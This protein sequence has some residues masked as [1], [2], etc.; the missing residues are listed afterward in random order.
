MPTSKA[1]ALRLWY[2]RK[3]WE[4]KFNAA[5]GR[6]EVWKGGKI[7]HA[8]YTSIEKVDRSLARGEL[9]YQPANNPKPINFSVADWRDYVLKV[10]LD[11]EYNPVED[12]FKALPTASKQPEV[13]IFERFFD[14]DYA[15]F[16][17]AGIKQEDALAYVREVSHLLFV[18]L[19]R[20]ATQAGCKYDQVTALYSEFGGIGKSD[21]VINLSPFPEL[22]WEGCTGAILSGD[23]VQLARK[24][25]GKWVI[26]VNEVNLTS[27]NKEAYK[28]NI[29]L[30]TYHYDEKFE[31]HRT[32]PRSDVMVCTTN[33]DRF[34]TKDESGYRRF[35]IVPVRFKEEMSSE[36][37]AAKMKEVRAKYF[38]A[39]IERFKEDGVYK[40]V[41]DLETIQ[42]RLAASFAYD[43][44]IEIDIMI[45][46]VRDWIMHNQDGEKFSIAEVCKNRGLNPRVMERH[47][48]VIMKTLK[49]KRV[50]TSERNL[51]VVKTDELPH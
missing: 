5:S 33:V 17:N 27:T 43:T 51:Y 13:S 1:G 29:T 14:I 37:A 48:P 25:R 22:V 38:A 18:N 6:V 40:P 7:L 36:D 47:M 23:E 20:R 12:Y 11:K 4:L 10:A 21:F 35:L 50:R 31:G 32:Y 34:L 30:Q 45:D 49:I 19:Y 16:A 24:S 41:G 26:Q 42:S 44:T 9:F 8:D 3:G 2:D 39:A 28:S 46:E 15:R